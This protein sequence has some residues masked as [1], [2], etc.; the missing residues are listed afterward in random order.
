MTENPAVWTIMPQAKD[1]VPIPR[2]N[3]VEKVPI[4]APL[5]FG[6]QRSTARAIRLG[7]LA[8]VPRPLSMAAAIMA[9][10]AGNRASNM[11]DDAVK[12]K[13]GMM[14]LARPHRSESLPKGPRVRRRMMANTEKKRPGLPIPF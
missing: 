10:N 6:P 14:V 13:P 4:A 12:K 9:Q 11:S 7:W 1:P 8:A 2:S 3:A 5:S